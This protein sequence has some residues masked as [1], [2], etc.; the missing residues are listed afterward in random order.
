[1]TIR[2]LPP[3]VCLLSLAAAA[4]APPCFRLEDLR[5]TATLTDPQVSP[6][7]QRIV[8][9]VARPNWEEDKND[10]ELDLVDA[11]TGASRAL[12]WKRSGLSSPRWSPDGG[13]LAFL[14]Q[15]PDT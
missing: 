13:R 11:A 10:Q 15:D 4:E 7:G 14:A 1:M 3:C 2:L 9:V 8:V 12:T 5:R 6:D